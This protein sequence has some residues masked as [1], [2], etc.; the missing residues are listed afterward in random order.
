LKKQ[1]KKSKLTVGT[2]LCKSKKN[3]RRKETHTYLAKKLYSPKRFNFQLWSS[4]LHKKERLL[5]QVL[6]FEK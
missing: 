4:P 3:E 2:T 1:T 5:S 6:P